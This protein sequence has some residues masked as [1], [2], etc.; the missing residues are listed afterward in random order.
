MEVVPSNLAH[1]IHRGD[2]SMIAAEYTFGKARVKINT[3]NICKTEEERE[4]VDRE[5][6]LACWSIVESLVDKGEAV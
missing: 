6:A 1:K 2:K 4:Q 3:E 5:I